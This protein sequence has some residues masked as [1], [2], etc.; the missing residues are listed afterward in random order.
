MSKNKLHY[1]WIMFVFL[2]FSAFIFVGLCSNTVSL[3]VQPVSD[4]FGFSR[5]A[6]R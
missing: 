6:L 5:G 4:A 2:I 1:S 3:F